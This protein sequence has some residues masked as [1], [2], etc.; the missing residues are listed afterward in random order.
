M[1]L[2][3]VIG[4]GK[5]AKSFNLETR[6][7][8]QLPRTSKRRGFHSAV[9]LLARVYAIGGLTIP[10]NQTEALVEC[11]NPAS[12]RWELVAPVREE[13]CLHESTVMKNKIF[14]VGR[15]DVQNV[16][17][18]SAEVYDPATNA[19]SFIA[20]LNHPRLDFGL[21]V[22]QYMMFVFGGGGT[23][24]IECYDSSSGE[25]KTVGSLVKRWNSLRC[26]LCALFQ[27]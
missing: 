9:G 6:T 16:P 12:N 11:F 14:V 13:R 1:G 7:W 3:Y 21:G 24:S 19:W 4:G 10:G 22:V 18:K 27:V 20:S 5:R 15:L 23:N 8:H 17:L 25:W 2:T 26:V